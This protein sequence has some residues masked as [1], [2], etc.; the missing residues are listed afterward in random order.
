MENEISENETP[1]Y[2]PD[3]IELN[4]QLGDIIEIVSP[5]NSIYHESTF[6]IHYIDQTQIQITNVNFLQKYQLNINENGNLTDESII[7]INLLSR[8]EV[9]GYAKQ[10]FLLP[11]TWID[12]HFGGEIPAIISGQISNLEEDMIEIITYPDMKTIYIDFK[13]QGIPIDFPIDKI[14][15]REKPSSLKNNVSLASLLESD[16]PSSI[17]SEE[18]SPSIDFLD[19]GESI[20]K[21]PEDTIAD[22]NIKDTLK[23][24]Y[25]EANTITFGEILEDITQLVEIPEN[26][27]KYSL[28]VQ[29]S[30]MMDELL[31]TIPNNKRTKSVLNNIHNLIERYV[32]LREKF[33]LFD[34]NNTVT[35]KKKNGVNYKPLAEKLYNVNY[36]LKWIIPIVMNRRKLQ[37]DNIN[38]EDEQIQDVLLQNMIEGFSSVIDMKNN[39]YKKGAN[40]N[41]VTYEA[42]QNKEKIVHRPFDNV[43]NNKNCI[44]IKEV[45]ENIDAVV[46]NL[47][48]FYSSVKKNSII[49]K[50]RFVI[51]K[52]NLGET[53]L[54]ETIMKSG[55]K[56][57]TISD[58]TKNDEI[59]IKSFLTL[60]ESVIKFSHIDLPSSSILNK[61]QLHQNYLLLFKL[62][63]KKTNVSSFIIKDFSKML[64]YEKIETESKES[65]FNGIHEFIIDTDSSESLELLDQNE[66]YRQ[67]VE[68]I[69]PHTRTLIKLYKKYIKNSLSFVDVVKKLEPFSIYTDDIEY[70]QYNEIRYFIK[71]QITSLKQK[72]SEKYSN[73]NILSNTKYNISFQV[74]SVLRVLSENSSFSDTFFKHYSFL[75]KDKLESKLSSSE[76][77]YQMY[78]TDNV[79]LYTNLIASILLSLNSADSILNSIESSVDDMGDSEKIKSDECGTKYLSKKYFSIAELQKDNDKDIL[80]FDEKFDDTPYEILDKYKKEKDEMPTDLFFDFFKENL[81]QRHGVPESNADELAETIIAK[82]KTVK[83]NHY[84]LLEILPKPKKSFDLDSISNMDLDSMENEAEI[85]KKIFYYRRLNNNWIKADDIDEESF[86]DNNTIFCN[87]SKN[88][89]KNDFNKICENSE[90]IKIRIKNLN[91]DAIKKEF[92]TR[93]ETTLEEIE[94][95]LNKKIAKHV[96]NKR[97]ND[98]LKE[99]DNYRANN[100]HF[101]IGK[102]IKN[103]ESIISPHEKLKN[104]ILGQED[105]SKKQYDICKFVD[106]YCRSAIADDS[107]EEKFW[108]YC[109]DTNTKLLPLSIHTLAKAYVTGMDYSLELEKVCAQY[110]T[111]SDDGE[112][113]VDKYSGFVLKIKDFD[114]EEGFDSSGKKLQ[115]R[116]VMQKE[117]GE[118]LVETNKVKQKIF[119]NPTTEMIYNTSLSILKN[120]NIPSD[121]LIETINRFVNMILDKSLLTESSYKKKSESNFKKTGKYLSKYE[122]YKNETTLTI[123]GAIIHVCVQTAIPSFT[124]NKTFPNCVRSFSGYPMTGMEDITGI[125]YIACV[126]IKMKSSITPWDSLVGMKQDKFSN[127]IKDILD[128]FIMTNLEIQELYLLKKEYISKNPE[129]IPP[130]E[131]KIEKWVHCLPPLIKTKIISKLKNISSDF[132]NDLIERIKKGDTKQNLSI[133]VLKTKAIE[134]GYGLIEIINNIVKDKDTLLKTSTGLPFLENA[135]CNE[136][137]TL[138]NPLL[139]FSN[140]DENIKV[141]LQRSKKIKN[142]LSDLNKLSTPKFFN[143]TENTFLK[144]P[145]LG[146]DYLEENIYHAF[147]HYCNIDKN[148]PIPLR[149]KTICSEFPDGYDSNMRMEEKIEFLKRNGKRFTISQ[150][151]QLMTIIHNDNIITK[152][153]AQSF[154]NVDAL[155]DLIDTFEINNSPLFEDNLRNYLKLVL[156]KYEPKKM[157]EVASPELENLTNYLFNVNNNLYKQIMEFFDKN[158]NQMNNREF[159]KIG[160]FLL[161]IHKWEFENQVDVHNI[162]KY[163]QNAT[164]NICKFYP[165]LLSNN[166]DFYKY[167]CKHWN[168]SENH[169]NDIYSFVEKYAKAIEKFK[170]DKVITQLLQ[171]MSI[172]LIDIQLFI[173]LIPKQ[174]EIVKKI[175][176]ENGEEVEIRFHG[177]FDKIT[178]FELLKYCFYRSIFEFMSACDDYDLIRTEITSIKKMVNDTKNNVNIADQIESNSVSINENYDNV[179][180]D[181]EESEIISDSPEELKSRVSNLL[182]SFLSVEMENKSS[183]NYSYKDIIKKVNRSKEREKKAIIDYLGNMSKEERN[184]EKL[185]KAYK[186][187]RWNVG[188]QK[189]LIEYDKNTY[190]RERNELLTQLYEDESTGKYEIVSEMRREIFDLEE[191]Q[192][193]ENEEF[194]DNEANDITQLDEDYMDGVYYDDDVVPEDEI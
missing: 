6:F 3:N 170:G 102:T 77:L 192:N 46:D 70:G 131:H 106:K 86:L 49:T 145:L 116:D 123:I 146:S 53:K 90:Q 14:I 163:L 61:T 135:C 108:F 150:L 34:D 129:L 18:N 133:N 32:G 60:P 73:F 153:K 96:K 87:L 118:S 63:N 78:L 147:I 162:G 141:L 54:K 134:N 39:Y 83:N 8:S 74:N 110:G 89:L 109:I 57:Y 182:H 165:T 85:R 99:I 132:K 166:A 186:L 122:K 127:R 19:T 168:F 71:E 16:D 120:I 173:Q 94:D 191:E 148:L 35:D 152:Y 117:L 138:I 124:V 149:L 119:E 176:N 66:K 105:F 189:G 30:D 20:I 95:K 44:T 113:I 92:D 161:F 4:L 185:F 7:Q 158:A 179:T 107:N 5:T 128:K 33:S 111:A 82:K 115:T 193:L 11:N 37:P 27:R 91:K 93:Y 80:Y 114:T 62:L 21:V 143:F 187:G 58:I 81:I 29:I 31:S 36:K 17:D 181:L 164:S 25:T 12:I 55:K 69:V 68:S 142:I 136:S 169:N 140:E 155:K 97:K 75:E 45:N 177:L 2:S 172:H 180:Q 159:D 15:I 137:M 126:M 22:E 188:Q 190:E 48:D 64:D 26:E 103:Y 125:Q 84:A 154:S 43:Y 194:Y 104:L 59:C 28:D 52:Y 10:N 144:Y 65:I 130:D 38:I 100:L 98:V 50:N 139:Y 67:F 101:E 175:I 157:H 88:C 13:Y 23:E 121:E 79:E 51:Q 72:L 183:I 184:V 56:I 1:V 171:H 41:A 151:H 9:K 76:M 160:N 178:Y 40:D 24:L 167:I 156:E 174:T 47:N 112:S 42:I